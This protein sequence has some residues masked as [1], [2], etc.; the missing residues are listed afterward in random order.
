MD[1]DRVLETRVHHG[2][3]VGLSRIYKGDVA[4]EAG[5]QD[6]VDRRAIVSTPR[7]LPS[8]K[9]SIVAHSPSALP[10]GSPEVTCPTTNL[11]SPEMAVSSNILELIAISA[12]G[13]PAAQRTTVNRVGPTVTL[14]C[15]LGVTRKRV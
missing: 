11:P 14:R 15:L 10:S 5:I 13:G 9:S 8:N 7:R 4:D 3:A 12:L 2:D 6:G 1:V